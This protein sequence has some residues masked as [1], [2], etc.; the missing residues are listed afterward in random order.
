[1]R[2]LEAL[3]HQPGLDPIEV[4]RLAAELESLR[5]RDEQPLLAPG[6]SGAA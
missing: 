3:L 1:M 4:E 2:K 5:R 6:S